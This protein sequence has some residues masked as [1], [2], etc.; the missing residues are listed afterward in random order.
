MSTEIP[1]SQ[2]IVQDG[3]IIERKVLINAGSP[4]SAPGGNGVFT[5]SEITTLPGGLQRGT[6]EYTRFGQTEAGQQAGSSGPQIELIGGSRDVPIQTHPKFA[7]LSE[8]DVLAITAAAEQKDASLLPESMEGAATTLYRM[9]RRN[10]THF[11]APSVVARVTQVESG[12]PSLAG[13]TTLDAP[14]GIDAP[15]ASKWVLTGVSARGFGGEFE[16]SREYTLIGDGIE[17]ASFL[18][19]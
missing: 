15:T 10:V 5:G 11:L 12:I 18:Y 13:L 19:S 1:G 6:F 7:D 3:K 9:L 8:D 17:F 2:V 4:P 14:P 16:V